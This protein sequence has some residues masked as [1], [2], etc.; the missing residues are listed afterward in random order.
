MVVDERG[1]LVWI[2]TR[3]DLRQRPDQDQP[4]PLVVGDVAARNLVTARPKETLRTAV[5]RM[6]A[7]GLRQLPLVAVDLSACCGAVNFWRP[8]SRRLA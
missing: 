2:V 5:R 1:W 8:M 3:S 7:S 6:N 4:R